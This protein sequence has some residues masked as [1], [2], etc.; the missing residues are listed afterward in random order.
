MFYAD[1]FRLSPIIL[2]IRFVLLETMCLSYLKKDYSFLIR[3]MFQ[4]IRKYADANRV[5]GHLV[6]IHVYLPH[7]LTVTLIAS[8]RTL[9]K[10]Q[11]F[12]A[13][14]YNKSINTCLLHN[15]RITSRLKSLRTYTCFCLQVSFTAI[16]NSYGFYYIARPIIYLSYNVQCI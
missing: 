15:N 14:G 12:E 13:I 8:T 3:L 2:M 6:Y 7:T 16:V 1:V 5:R 9:T 10:Q 4:K 11:I